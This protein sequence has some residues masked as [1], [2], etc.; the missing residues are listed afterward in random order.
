MCAK[1]VG[2]GAGGSLAEEVGRMPP[3]DSGA[4]EVEVDVPLGSE[5]W[6]GG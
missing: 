3:A 5:A 6:D 4:V 2:Y 1:D